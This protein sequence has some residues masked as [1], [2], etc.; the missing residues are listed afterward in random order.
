MRFVTAFVIACL[1]LVQSGPAALTPATGVPVPDAPASP[2]AHPPAPASTRSHQRTPTSHW[3]DGVRRVTLENGLTVLLL[4]RGTLPIVSVQALYKVGSRNEWP[5]ATGSAHYIEHMAFRRT[6]RINKGDLTNQVLRWGGRWGGYTSYDQ[7]VYNAH[8][9]SAYLDWLV[10]MERQRMRHVLFDAESVELERTSVISEL[11]EYEN[12]PSYTMA[13]H[14]LRRAAMVA[15]PYGSPIMGWVSDLQTV[16]P[17]DLER[18]YRDHYAPNNLVLV[19]VGRFDEAEA[20]A[21]VRKHFA[22]APGD[23]RPTRLRTVEPEQTGARRIVHR[24][25]GSA[26]HLELLVHAPAVSDAR[27][28]TLLVLDAVLAGGKAEGRASARPGSRLHTALVGTGL[29]YGVSTE[30]ELSEHPGLHAIG[31]SAGPDADLAKVEAALDRALAAAGRDITDTEVAAAVQQV[32][33]AFALRDDSNRAIADRLARFEGIGSYTLLPRI[34]DAVGTVSAADVRA[35]AAE[36]FAADRRNVGWFVPKA[37]A[38]RTPSGQDATAQQEGAKAPPEEIA[39]KHPGTATPPAPRLDLPTLPSVSLTTLPNGLTVG[40]APLGGDIV[41]VRVRV[42]A[43]ALAD[44]GGREGLAMVAARA[45]TAR[46]AEAHA[47]QL[48]ARGIRIQGSAN[49]LDEPFDNRAFV[50]WTATMRRDDLQAVLTALA[51][52]LARPEFGTE[53]ITRARDGLADDAGSLQDDSRWR[54]NDAA[55]SALFPATHPLGRPV[56]GTSTSL[57]SITVDDVAR[58]HRARYHPAGTTVVVS[59]GVSE[60]DAAA[61]VTAAFGQWRASTPPAGTATGGRVVSLTSGDIPVPGG[62]GRDVHI[63][64][65]HKEQASITVA[66]PAAAADSADY[67]ALSLLNYLLGET[68]YAGRLGERLVDTG[69]AYAVYASLWPHRGTGPLLV[70]TDAVLSREAVARMRAALADFS[71]RGLTAAQLDEAKGFAL[72]RL[73]FRFETPAAASAAVADL[74]SL[75]QGP[76]G[77]QSFGERIKAVTLEQLNAAAS[78]YY[79][80]ERAVFVVVGR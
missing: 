50:E 51:D 3:T 30:V 79:D 80:P 12:S 36:L 24:G 47:A 17:A 61:A 72:G 26:S 20:L 68:G 44:P 76:K 19:I 42:A 34:V 63:P 7:T 38:A 54:A 21:L 4:Q 28:P 5:G 22:D 57:T 2:R 14:R 74:A 49:S 48:G 40:V 11:R 15:H 67:P 73:L 66:L 23:G 58:F 43:G 25:P 62:G 70:T 37:E 39:Q 35:L 29:A 18:F 45:I 53:T 16:T 32:L 52:V 77:L 69:I 13:E 60:R 8:A 46:A 71:T 6:E 1:G 33:A 64:M 31:V 55:W 9:P 10:F 59:G 27:Y 78:K 41:H 56:Q 65:P 75:G